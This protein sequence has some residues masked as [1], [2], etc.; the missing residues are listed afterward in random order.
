[1]DRGWDAPLDY[2][3]PLRHSA[4]LGLIF[5]GLFGAI[6]S[7]PPSQW[8]KIIRHLLLIVCR[9]RRRRQQITKRRRDPSSRER[10]SMWNTKSQFSTCTSTYFAA[11]YCSIALC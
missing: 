4:A 2:L 1:M 9:L 5:I 10:L 3:L 7:R 11:Y 8:A 6:S